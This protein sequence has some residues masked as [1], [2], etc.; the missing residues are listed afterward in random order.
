MS[1]SPPDTGDSIYSNNSDGLFIVTE[2][3]NPILAQLRQSI[4]SNEDESDY[5]HIGPETVVP[6]RKYSRTCS[7]LKN[8]LSSEEL[9]DC[10][11]LEFPESGRG[12]SRESSE[13]SDIC[14]EGSWNS[15][16]VLN[17][18]VSPDTKPVD[19]HVLVD[20]ADSQCTFSSGLSVKNDL[21]TSTV[22]QYREKLDLPIVSH[23]QRRMPITSNAPVI[24]RSMDDQI[25]ACN[26]LQLH[27]SVTN[28]DPPLT[29]YHC[30]GIDEEEETPTNILNIP[31]PVTHGR[32]P[33]L[34]S[35][36]DSN[37]CRKQET[38][39][40]S[41]SD[42]DLP[43]DTTNDKL[44]FRR[45]LSMQ[46]VKLNVKVHSSPKL[47]S[48]VHSC[49]SSPETASCLNSFGSME[50]LTADAIDEIAEFSLFYDSPEASPSHHN[51]GHRSSLQTTEESISEESEDVATCLPLVKVRSSPRLTVSTKSKR[52][53]SAYLLNIPSP[54][55][56]NPPSNL[57]TSA[58]T[59]APP[60]PVSHDPTPPTIPRRTSSLFPS[61]SRVP[62][63][64][65]IAQ[66]RR[67]SSMMCINHEP[68][69]SKNKIK[70][71]FGKML[72]TRKM[73]VPVTMSPVPNI[74]FN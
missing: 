22:K 17:K 23:R 3:L 69:T 25:S 16:P 47:S 29:E 72:R 11:V 6:M 65:L 42:K 8:S 68:P 7:S 49:T 46:S 40:N 45:S 56:L 52:P 28:L 62:D 20:Q 21:S 13:I 59:P 44:L 51:P 64:E 73:S 57:S 74:S 60:T 50:L 70:N 54:T 71:A 31:Q 39:P 55:D 67:L 32:R 34:S 10:S 4:S 41:I 58:P 30:S 66:A 27:V 5:S 14:F 53:T 48:P 24:V 38:V 1:P 15:K 36:S 18:P 61:I 19:I 63:K 12:F 35:I 2:R 37:L 33:L 26:R 9:E 43:P